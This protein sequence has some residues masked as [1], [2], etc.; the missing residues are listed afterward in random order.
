MTPLEGKAEWLKMSDSVW[1]HN[2]SPALNP[3]TAQLEERVKVHVDLLT[4]LRCLGHMYTGEGQDC[5]IMT[6]SAHRAD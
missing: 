3:P 5:S 4:P 2:G 1:H 6:I